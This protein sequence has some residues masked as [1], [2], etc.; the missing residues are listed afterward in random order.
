ML[1]KAKW[2]C[3]PIDPKEQAVVYKK[4]FSL[5][6]K[7]RKAELEV[8]ALGIYE[9]AI[10]GHR[11]GD[12]ILAPGATSTKRVQVQK[13]DVLPLLKE[14]NSL[15]IYLGNGWF[16]GGM[17]QLNK[18]NFPD[19]YQAIIA[20]LTVW[21]EDGSQKSIV[22]DENWEV[23]LSKIRLADIY[24]GEIY[25]NLYEEE[26]VPVKLEKYPFVDLVFQ[27][28][29][30]VVENERIS[31]IEIFK[32]ANGDTIVDFG[33][34]MAGYVETNLTAKAGDR[35]SFSFAE[36]LDKDG[37]FYNLNYNYAQSQYVYVCKNGK[38]TYKP[39]L[40]YY[41]FRY[42]KVNEF[43]GEITKD[44]IRAV[45]L[46]S[47]MERTG[48]LN[49]SNSLLNR[50][51][52]N[53][54]WGQKSNFLDI[55]TDCPQRDERMGWLGDA[56]VFIRTATYNFDVE[57]F[58]IKWFSDLILEQS[59]TGAI[60]RIVPNYWAH[61]GNKKAS[62][63]W[64]DALT[65]CPWQIYV[66][67][68]NKS[69]LEKMYPTIKRYLECIKNETEEE[70]LW[71]GASTYGDWLSFETETDKE[72]LCS[73]YYSH[74]VDLAAKIALVLGDNIQA[75]IYRQLHEKIVQKINS[76]FTSYKTQAEKVLAL[77]F[78]IAQDP[79]GVA[80]SLV[81]SIILNGYKLTTGFLTTPYLLHVLSRYGYS[82]IAYKLLLQTEMPSWLY[83]V[84]RGA[85]T[86]WE[87]WDSIKENG[88]FFDP[89]M[90]S[91]NH[92]AYGAVIDWVYSV[93]CGIKP[94]D[95]APGYEK[96]VVEPIATNQIDH[97]S[98][99]LKTRVG[100]IT[101]RWYH[102]DGK[103]RYEITVPKQATIIIDGK[104]YCVDKGT[105]IF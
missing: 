19:K 101:S 8:T 17:N 5:D 68:G 11:V 50:F 54:I 31:P 64:T 7:L 73:A 74:S 81:E 102:Q 89:K 71:I 65:I 40:T 15:E 62:P 77:Y 44:N 3:Y 85:T 42:V 35:V 22:T 43:P 28:G 38:Q 25:D 78:D 91:F 33:Q 14:C 26:F 76:R 99:K 69:V 49:S 100:E 66:S 16:R 94:V 95:S 37:K 56:Q 24:N 92:Y 48:W 41:G 98:A 23:S 12:F 83:P 18:K 36:V 21:S 6:K 84:T 63:G 32:D 80:S 10:N 86:V 20:R 51:F 96:I 59:E 87:R 2:I 75:K 39:K 82:E 45:V 57:K 72:F 53:V 60:P 93:A 46:H 4:T 27:E 103:I 34:N 52:S 79:L 97:L 70:Y 9:A 105:H 61:V 47:K 13:Y 90:N 104:L 29:E 88:E 1:E 30:Y 55:P 58:Y 67:Y